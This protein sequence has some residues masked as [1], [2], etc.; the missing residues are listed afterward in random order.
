[1]QSHNVDGVL[2]QIGYWKCAR[3]FLAQALAYTASDKALYQNR[4]LATR[5]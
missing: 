4:G 2:R 1:M 3:P 5:D